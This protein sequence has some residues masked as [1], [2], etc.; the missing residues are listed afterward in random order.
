[1]YEILGQL[2]GIICILLETTTELTALCLPVPAVDLRP[3]RDAGSLL[4]SL[5]LTPGLGEGTEKVPLPNPPVL[6]GPES[7]DGPYQNWGLLSHKYK[8]LNPGISKEAL[9]VTLTSPAELSILIDYFNKYPLLGTKGKDFKDWE[10]I[11]SLIISKEH[12][13]ESGKTLIKTIA[14]NM[15]SKRYK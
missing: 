1:M 12:L 6:D 5:R 10:K 4:R 3:V 13:T 15:N 9:S 11:N 2:A 14:S 7:Y 8:T